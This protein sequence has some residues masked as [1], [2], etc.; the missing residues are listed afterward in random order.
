MDLPSIRASVAAALGAGVRHLV[1]VSVAHP[2]P[3]MRAYIAV[4]RGR[5]A[6]P[7]E[8]PG[9]DGPPPLVRAGPGS[10]LA[11]L[12]L[13]IYALLARLPSTRDGA[14]RLGLV[15]REQML[16]ALVRA[17]E[18]PPTNVRVIGVPDRHATNT[19]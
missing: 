11:Y 10:P 9:G 13:P 3:V 8:R 16:R 4:R 17:V 15:T 5:A 1:Y 7:G 6:D 12:L 2:A 19:A 14:Q 18:D